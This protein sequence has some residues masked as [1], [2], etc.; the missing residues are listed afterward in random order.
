MDHA[1][2]RCRK[3]SSQAL[4]VVLLLKTALTACALVFGGTPRTLLPHDDVLHVDAHVAAG[5]GPHHDVEAAG[6]ERSPLYRWSYHLEHDNSSEWLL[7]C[8]RVAQCHARGVG[9][10]G[11]ARYAV[12]CDQAPHVCPDS[13][14]QRMRSA[15]AHTCTSRC[16]HFTVRRDHA[17]MS[18]VRCREQASQLLVGLLLTEPAACALCFD[19]APPRALTVL[20]GAPHLDIEAAGAE[21]SPHW[22]VHHDT[23]S[24]GWLMYYQREAECHTHLAMLGVVE[25]YAN[26][27]LIVSGATTMDLE[28]SA[29]RPRSTN[30][31]A[32]AHPCPPPWPTSHESSPLC[33]S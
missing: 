11:T 10:D 27:E 31:S 9:D 19:G 1:D 14:A 2:Q 7:Y 15:R 8:Q 5:L 18:R 21:R 26:G 17:S 13:R 16:M 12:Q 3:R 23:G 33:T 25:R 22:S 29:R 20:A 6:A 30:L 28:A 32:G 4:L 24:P